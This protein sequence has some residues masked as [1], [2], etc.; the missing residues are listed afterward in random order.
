[1][2]K[3]ALLSFFLAF[4]LLASIYAE[5]AAAFSWPK[6][7]WSGV[8]NFFSTLKNN[9]GGGAAGAVAGAKVGAS[10]GAAIG[11]PP[12]AAIGAIVGG[13]GGYIAG[14]HIEQKIKEKVASTPLGKWFGLESGDSTNP[15][16]SLQTAKNI[17]KEEFVNDTPIKNALVQNLTEQ[18]DQAAYQ[19]IQILLSK[20][21]STLTNYDFQESGDS[22]EFMSVSLK[23][24]ASIYGF[25][26]FPVEFR[27][28]VRGNSETKDPICLTSIKIYAKDTQNGN[29]YW[30]RTWNFADGEKCGEE[31]TSWSFET[32]LKGPDPYSGYINSVLSGQANEALI[33]EIFNAEP[34]EYE[35]IVEVTGYREIYYYS[36]G[37]WIYDHR[38]NINAQFSSLSA[39]RHIAAGTYVVGGFAGSLPISF[40]DAPEASQFT[41]FQMTAA[42]ASSNLVAR[43]WS[44]PIHILN[45]TAPYRF[46]VQGNPGY[47]GSLNPQITDEARIVVYRILKNGNWELA[48]AIPLEGVTNLGDLSVGKLLQASVNY[49]ADSETISYRAF[50]A[51]KAWVQ[52]DDGQQIP[53]W[54][55]VE[56]AIA[57]VDP[58]RKMIMD[59]YVTEIGDLTSDNVISAA[60]AQRLQAIADSLISSL[61][62]KIEVAED[63]KSKGENENKEEVVT[64]ASKAISHYNE[65]IKY[66]NKLK[67]ADNSQDVLRYAEIV[68]EEE[69]AGDY[70]LR[71]AEIAYYGQVEQAQSLVKNAEKLEQTIKEYKGGF[72]GILPDFSNTNEVVQFAI[73]VALS[74]VAIYIS[75]KLLGGI[76]ALIVLGIVFVWWIGPLFGIHL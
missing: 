8:T 30:T 1:M 54:I 33:S 74:I 46:Y 27:L 76:G 7:N 20:L 61:Q 73:K 58:N 36:N 5:P 4:M 51:V 17:T 26:A 44:S 28:T 49:H 55:L 45:A 68:K 62:S 53:V 47:F 29:I 70:Y 21:Q 23:G 52:R 66:A 24:P 32:I 31:G 57:P 43:L 50:V 59:E 60:E 40:K 72:G 71:A 12:G 18:T 16:L 64:Y 2:N 63:W 69:A 14:S 42:G 48:Y 38:E 25:S 22:G 37:Q 6:P 41:A 39:Y 3:H 13:I 19:D 15:S 10:I 75:R 9:V 34:Q 11:G 67:S 56:P 65:A 35:I